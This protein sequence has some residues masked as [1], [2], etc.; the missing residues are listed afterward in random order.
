MYEIKDYFQKGVIIISL[1]L[2][3]LSISSLARGIEIYKWKDKDGNVFFSDTPPPAGVNGEAIS[4]KDERPPDSISTPGVNSPRPRD[5]IT[6]GKRPYDSIKVTMYVTSWC[7]YCRKAREYLQS[8]R[9]DLVEYDVEKNPS[10]A[11]EMVSKS[12]GSRGV[13]LIDVEGI[14]IRG[15]SPGAIKD[16]VEKRRNS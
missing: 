6:A 11:K 12:G 16:A 1:L 8:L 7:G 5:G 14:I 4:F 3:F 15:Y 2:F 10:R 9:V 13:P